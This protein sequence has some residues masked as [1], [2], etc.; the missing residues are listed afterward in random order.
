MYNVGFK[1]RAFTISYLY[2]RYTSWHESFE[3]KMHNWK[4]F[5]LGHLL[6]QALI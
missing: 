3:R 2:V 5:N 1:C 4:M 6:R